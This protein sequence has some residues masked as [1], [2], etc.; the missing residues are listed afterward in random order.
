MYDGDY[1]RIQCQGT[2]ENRPDNIIYSTPTFKLY[3]PVTNFWYFFFNDISQQSTY[4]KTLFLYFVSGHNQLANFLVRNIL[5]VTVL[6][7]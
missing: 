1:E 2:R 4:Q 5:F 6:I 7:G 3:F